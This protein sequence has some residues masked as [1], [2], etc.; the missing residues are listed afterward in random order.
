MLNGGPYSVTSDVMKKTRM[1]QSKAHV[2]TVWQASR[3][4][5]QFQPTSLLLIDGPAV[6]SVLYR[7]VEQLVAHRAHNPKVAGSNPAPATTT[8]VD[9]TVSACFFMDPD[10]LWALYFIDPGPLSCLPAFCKLL[11]QLPCLAP[12][13]QQ[14]FHPANSCRQ[15]NQSISSLSTG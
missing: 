13:D 5:H 2:F 10:F 12:V 1:R 7:G 9:L 8:G 4:V 15:T 14:T 11:S 6:Y 3:D